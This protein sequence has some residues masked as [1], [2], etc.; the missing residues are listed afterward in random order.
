ME[1]AA[2]GGKEAGMPGEPGEARELGRGQRGGR[3]PRKGQPPSLP[4]EVVVT[5]LWW[6]SPHKGVA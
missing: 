6:S 2:C 3:G 4:Q 5:D 1:W